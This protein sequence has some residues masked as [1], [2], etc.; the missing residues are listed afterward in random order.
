MR[1]IN[2]THQKLLE[3]QN[4]HNPAMSIRDM[5]EVLGTDSPSYVKWLLDKLVAAGLAEKIQRGSKHVYRMVEPKYQHNSER[6]E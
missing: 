2:E 4:A 5:G 6:H 1:D 3:A